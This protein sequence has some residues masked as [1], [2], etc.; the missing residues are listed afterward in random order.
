MQVLRRRE[1]RVTEA[2]GVKMKETKHG[3]LSGDVILG[4][5]SPPKTRQ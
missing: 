5:V 4:R 1:L 3:F 2:L